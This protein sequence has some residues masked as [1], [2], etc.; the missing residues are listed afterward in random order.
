MALTMPAKRPQFSVATLLFATLLAG[1][2]VSIYLGNVGEVSFQ[3][4]NG[5]VVVSHDEILS[6]DWES[7]SYK[8]T[9]VAISRL[10]EMNFSGFGLWSEFSLMIDDDLVASGNFVSA[11]AAS[12]G[13]RSPVIRLPTGP[14]HVD[15]ILILGD[16]NPRDSDRLY[17]CLWLAGKLDN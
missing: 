13:R 7:Q 11:A 16:P 6:V 4:M 17:K 2:A 3:D 15:S 1:L 5:R 10:T 14:K 8:L 9:D 12:M